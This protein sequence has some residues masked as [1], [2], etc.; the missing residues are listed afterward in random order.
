MVS[1]LEENILEI[2]RGATRTLVISVIDEENED[3]PL[4][5]SGGKIYFTVKEST[6][7]REHLIRKTSD[8]PAEITITD[9]NGG[10]AE[11]YLLPKDTFHLQV[12]VEYVYDCWVEFTATDQRYPVVETSIFKVKDTVTR[13][14]LP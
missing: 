7:D 12:G 2:P 4:S 5:L 8:V 10:E 11:I 9:P 1:M 14:P 3:Q 13:I 6:R